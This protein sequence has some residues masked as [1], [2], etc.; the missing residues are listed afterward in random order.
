M[1]RTIADGGDSARM[2]INLG[3]LELSEGHL[4]AARATLE[5]A[6]GK[7]PESALAQLNLAAVKIKERDFAGARELLKKITEPPELQARAEESLAVLENRETGMVDLM[8]LRLAVAARAFELDDRAA[9]HQSAGRCRL[10][11]SRHHRV[12]DLSRGCALSGGK[13]ADDEPAVAQ[14]WPA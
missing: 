9:L 2:L 1:T 8:R 14:D 6:L 11:R 5:S 12:A 10:S 13:L 7:E 4:E 3:G